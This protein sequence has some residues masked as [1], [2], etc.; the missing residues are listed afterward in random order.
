MMKK[1]LFMVIALLAVSC[2]MAAG[3]YTSAMVSN[4]ATLTVTSTSDS[5]VALTAKHVT[6]PNLPGETGF[7][8][9]TAEI[10]NNVLSFNF[11]RGTYNADTQSFDWGLQPNSTYAWWDFHNEYG[12]FQVTNNSEDTIALGILEN[13][14]DEI[15]D[16]GFIMSIY[17]QDGN[18][19]YSGNWEDAGNVD[20]EM[21][22]SEDAGLG[23][24][25]GD[26]V[27]GVMFGPEPDENN[28][29]PFLAPGE[30][31]EIGVR[32]NL[33][34]FASNSTDFFEINV[35]TGPVPVQPVN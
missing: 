19:R 17:D 25:G 16:F 26:A 34:E 14:A 5:L 13:C 4:A 7:K 15:G 3:A 2:L 27:S 20:A 35:I 6:V 8:D 21:T 12:L 10:Q 33:S 11:N 23:V 30:T 24:I 29:P 1:G 9:T 28:E 31:A 32:I 22:G 18:L